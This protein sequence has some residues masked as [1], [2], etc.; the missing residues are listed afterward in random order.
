[1]S[2]AGVFY[3]ELEK[4]SV[5]S[6]A[7]LQGD[8][9]LAED[10]EIGPYAIIK[11]PVTI[12]K[13][14]VVEERA[15]IQGPTV[16]G[17]GNRI[18][19]SALVGG[20]PQDLSFTGEESYL[21]I[22]DHNIIREYATIHRGASKGSETVIGS[23]N[24]FMGMVHI[25]HDCT[26]GDHV[27]IGNGSVVAGHVELAECALI[28]GIVAIHQFVKVGRLGMAGGMTRVNRD[29]PPF[30]TVV[31]NS[32]LVGLNTVGLQ[33]QGVPAESRKAIKHAFRMLF[34]SKLTLTDAIA[35]LKQTDSVPEVEELVDF[36]TGSERGL[37]RFR[38][39]SSCC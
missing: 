9:E 12:G 35:K 33:R 20:D 4:M 34:R 25:A 22:G 36:C 8:V 37:C 39:E 5:H 17:E 16:I 18:C 2:A 24:L 38:G 7:I 27:I 23:H 29:I 14:T 26:I 6:T 32:G 28:S 13:G 3:G 30:T 15:T 10:V 31:G 1:M 19:C 21:K 11:G